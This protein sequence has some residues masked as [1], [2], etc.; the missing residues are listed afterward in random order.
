MNPRAAGNSGIVNADS[1][2]VNT[3]SGKT[4]KVF[5]IDQNQCSCSFGMGVHVQ[6]EWL[7]TLGRNMHGYKSLCYYVTVEDLINVSSFV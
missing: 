6:S 5:I 1:G 7:F 4:G 3:H 2:I